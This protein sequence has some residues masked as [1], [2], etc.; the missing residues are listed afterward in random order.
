MRNDVGE[1]Y[2]SLLDRFLTLPAS[3]ETKVSR[4]TVLNDEERDANSARK[5]EETALLAKLTFYDAR[6]RF[7]D[8]IF[9]SSLSESSTYFSLCRTSLLLSNT[10]LLDRS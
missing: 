9:L 1:M 5:A 3:P 6:D 10:D 7:Q 8:D 2:Q 4:E